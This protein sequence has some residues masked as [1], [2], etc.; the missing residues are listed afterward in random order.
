MI[1]CSCNAIS[2]RDVDSA[3]EGGACPPCEVYARCGKQPQCGGC[4]KTILAHLRAQMTISDDAQ[5]IA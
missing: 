1:V 4:V 3:I 2:H 5:A